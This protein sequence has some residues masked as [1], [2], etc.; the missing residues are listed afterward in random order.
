MEKISQRDIAILFSALMS[1]D[2]LKSVVSNIR[3][4]GFHSIF[5]DCHTSKKGS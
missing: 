5:V 1:E 2:K 3:F 4:K